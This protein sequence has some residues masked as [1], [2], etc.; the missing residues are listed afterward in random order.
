MAKIE[1]IKGQ[2]LI[3]KAIDS[4]K[5]RGAKLDASIQQAGVSV[6]AHASEHG[7]TTCADRLVAAMPKGARKLALV[8][9]AL[10]F[11]QVR[12]LNKANPDEAARIKEGATFKLDRSKTL[13]IDSACEKLW[14]EFRKEADV[15]TAFDA[16]K[17]VASVLARM[18]TAANNGLSIEHKAEALKEAQA[19]VAML[20]TAE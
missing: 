2:A 11:G 10:A 20:E 15:A 6:L 9:W 14:H 3:I 8:E 17:A 7:D 4:I 5:N 13:D 1:I 16:Q 19:L 18:R 12:L